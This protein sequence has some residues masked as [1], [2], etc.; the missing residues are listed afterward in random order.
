MYTTIIRGLAGSAIIKLTLKTEG[1]EFQPKFDP[2]PMSNSIA[3]K[4]AW[5][6]INHGVSMSLCNTVYYG[7]DLGITTVPTSISFVW[8]PALVSIWR[9]K[10]LDKFATVALNCTVLPQKLIFADSIF[11]P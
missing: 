8:I 1:R 11:N 4:K 3:S 2:A 5:K 7:I 10:N 9:N 6:E